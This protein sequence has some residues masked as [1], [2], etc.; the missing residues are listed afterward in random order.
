MSICCFVVLC[1]LLSFRN[2]PDPLPLLPATCDAAM[3]ADA[4]I[5]RVTRNDRS[6]GILVPALL[7]GSH[8]FLCVRSHRGDGF[9]RVRGL[10]S[11][12]GRFESSTSSS[13]LK[14]E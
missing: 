9:G 2:K 1:C 3:A 14:D 11:W 10:S 12:I 6:E 13:M 5:T 8:L 7:K 4:P